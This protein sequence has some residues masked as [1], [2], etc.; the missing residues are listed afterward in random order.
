M[1]VNLRFN[2]YKQKGQHYYNSI[3]RLPKRV[4]IFSEYIFV[5][6]LCIPDNYVSLNVKAEGNKFKNDLF[7]LNIL[8]ESE[9]SPELS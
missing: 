3:K 6:C 7:D 8:Q 1:Y 4:N 2:I 5:I 9:I